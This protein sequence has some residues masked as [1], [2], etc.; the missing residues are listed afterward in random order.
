MCQTAPSPTQL[1]MSD[2]VNRTMTRSHASNGP[3]QSR[4]P[5]AVDS[6]LAESKV[7]QEPAQS[8]EPGTGGRGAL[9]AIAT[10][11]TS[12]SKVVVTRRMI[13]RRIETMKCTSIRVTLG[14]VSVQEVGPASEMIEVV[15]DEK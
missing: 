7:S 9:A 1:E 3:A 4:E 14:S 11:P 6:G 13:T 2:V 10:A 15:E 12:R 5:V 8:L